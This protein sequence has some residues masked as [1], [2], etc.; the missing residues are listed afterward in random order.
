[1]VQQMP[2]LRKQLSAEKQEL[3]LLKQFSAGQQEQPVEHPSF[4]ALHK[5][6]YLFT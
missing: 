3:V 1:M 2:V 6:L 4:S 5:S